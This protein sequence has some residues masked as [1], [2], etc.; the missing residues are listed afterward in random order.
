M[1][2]TE[3]QDVVVKPPSPHAWKLAYQFIVS[4]ILPRMIRNETNREE[5]K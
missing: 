3:Q 5:K 1:K 4:S 2:P